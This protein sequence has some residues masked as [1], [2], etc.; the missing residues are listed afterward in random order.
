MR[1][2]ATNIVAKVLVIN[3]YNFA[4][5]TNSSRI[6]LTQQVLRPLL[7]KIFISVLKDALS[8]ELGGNDTSII[9]FSSTLYSSGRKHILSI[10]Q[11][12]QRSTGHA[13]HRPRI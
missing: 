8:N 12:H 5:R 9:I 3:I 10:G 6:Y 1:K 13:N 2:L 4:E 7:T 11:S